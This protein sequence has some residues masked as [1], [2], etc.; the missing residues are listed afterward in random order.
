MK[1]LLFTFP[2]FLLI[3]FSGNAQTVTKSGN[4]TT[5]DAVC[6]KIST[7]YEVSRPSGFTS[8]QITWSATGGEI[9]GAKNNP[10]VTVIWDDTPGATGTV[11]ATFS[12]CATADSDNNGKTATLSQLILSVKDQSWGSYGSSVVVDYCTR[13]QVG[14]SVPRMYV[15]GTGGTSKVPLKEVTY[16]WTLPAGWREVGTGR[17]GTFGTFANAIIIE[18]IGCSV[19]G[20]VTVQ[21]VINI[22][23]FFC[24]S[25]A[26]SATATINLI[27]PI[28]TATITVPQGY[29]GSRACDRNP[30]V[31]TAL[32]NPSLS[33]VKDY[34]WSYPA[35]W[36]FVSQSANTI[37]LRPSGNPTDVGTVR[38]TV[39]FTCGSSVSGI[40]TVQF[41]TPVV[42]GTS[43]LCSSAPYTILNA[44]PNPTVSWS[45]NNA[46]VSITSTGVA[47]RLNN[48]NGPASILA[49]VCGTA[50]TPR[51][52][53]VGFTPRVPAQTN[54]VLLA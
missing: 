5:N 8:C 22:Q 37:T 49:T 39:N 35:G 33:C 42:S 50:A 19:A 2:L 36:T 38:G 44:A 41:I 30:V 25:A 29:T 20:K 11:T 54:V 17:T 14:L 45:T 31:F 15:Q 26:P 48:Y 9:Q 28:P 27:S 16:S 53:Y 24:G 23:P 21:G 13:A 12:N 52:I 10:T 7:S 4:N 51:A 6:P 3:Y 1:K 46:N 47:S 40:A 32:L 43:L 34:Q 18:P